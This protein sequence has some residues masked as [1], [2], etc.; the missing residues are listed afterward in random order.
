MSESIVGAFNR[1]D[2]GKSY[3]SIGK[4]N[5]RSL[6]IIEGEARAR[7]LEVCLLAEKVLPGRA[8]FG[9]SQLAT[10]GLA[11]RQP[12]SSKAQHGIT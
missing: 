3:Q 8:H 1:A 9:H 12:Y 6:L 7:Q 11:C 10:L 2:K 4:K 5:V